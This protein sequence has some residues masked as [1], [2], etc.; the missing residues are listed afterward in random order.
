[1]RR[2]RPFAFGAWLAL[3]AVLAFVVREHYLLTAVVD[4]PIV[5]DAREYVTYA[6]N[7]VHHG[8]FSSAA[9]PQAPLPD[10]YRSPGY[11][12]LIA[13]GMQRWPQTGWYVFV[14]HL[15]AILGAL[16]TVLVGL[17]ARRWLRPGWSI[18]AALVLALWPHHVAATNTLLSE[19]VFGFFLL[20]SLYAFARAW[21]S[22]SAAWFALAGA[23]LGYAWL[24]NPVVL[25][26][27]PIVAALAWFH[28]RRRAAAL[29]L[30]VF[31]VPV[32]GLSVRNASVDLHGRGST[33]RATLNLVQGSW[34]D[35]HN[36]ANR[37]RTGDPMAVAIMQEIDAEDA[38]LRASPAKG[39]SRIASR[40]AARPWMYLQWYASKPWVLWGWQIRIGGTD[41][42]YHRVGNSPFDRN[43][44][45]RA[46]LV[47]YRV[48]NPL[49]TTLLLI[50]AIA[51]VRAGLRSA[52][53]V[54][55]AATGALALYVT[56]VHVV[57]QADPRYATAYRGIEALL[58]ATAIA[59][60]WGLRRRANSTGHESD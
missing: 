55:A 19:V 30:A 39:M 38:E 18:F 54:P 36:A 52:T 57:L 15:Q 41:I 11:P 53:S 17:I 60:C 27:P 59:W 45:L 33:Q 48:L 5:G 31:L 56:L 43:P 58:V 16:S 14:L 29:L 23:A 21:T 24:V 44:V 26:F 37:F 32:I 47:A 3:V 8:V 35:Y 46:V 10:S 7:L 22:G 13:L 40:L 51:V 20:L 42:S 28:G 6:W 50:A 49:L 34:P 4:A 2:S 12:W 9:P 25:L 1:M